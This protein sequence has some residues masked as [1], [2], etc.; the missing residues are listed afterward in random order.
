MRW[1][2][3]ALPGSK[4]LA[5]AARPQLAR[6][7]VLHGR[8]LLRSAVAYNSHARPH[9]PRAL[10]PPRR[11]VY[12]SI[13]SE[14]VSTEKFGAID[15]RPVCVNPD[16]FL[17][18]KQRLAGYPHNSF[19][20][21]GHKIRETES[22]VR[23]DIIVRPYRRLNSLCWPRPLQRICATKELQR[24]ESSRSLP[25]ARHP[26]RRC[27]LGSHQPRR[28]STMVVLKSLEMSS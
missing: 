8:L 27:L 7:S 2:G 18:S 19:A 9:L 26:N 25:V 23:R 10:R 16:I 13:S 21:Q 15:A 3:L 5:D 11:C 14:N 24:A 20:K 4:D 1:Q 6:L 12:I 17:I 22:D 28:D